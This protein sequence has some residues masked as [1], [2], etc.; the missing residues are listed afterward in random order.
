MPTRFFAKFLS[1]FAVLGL[2][3]S[4]EGQRVLLL[5]CQK[6]LRIGAVAWNNFATDWNNGGKKR[7]L[8]SLDRNRFVPKNGEEGSEQVKLIRQLAEE[9]DK[10][11]LIEFREQNEMALVESNGN[12][13]IKVEK[14]DQLGAIHEGVDTAF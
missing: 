14:L 10:L 2:S 4:P 1:L 7:I 6:T 13:L 5:T 3:Q 8:D 11:P 9:A 12:E